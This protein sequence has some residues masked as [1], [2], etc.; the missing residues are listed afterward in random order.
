M[1]ARADVRRP[2]VLSWLA[3]IFESHCHACTAARR[4]PR[5]PA[6]IF[7]GLYRPRAEPHVREG[8]A[9]ENNERE[10]IKVLDFGIA[11]VEWAE[12]RLTNSEIALG[13]PGYRSPEQEQG[14]EVDA[15]TDLYGLGAVLLECLTG[16]LPPAGPRASDSGESSSSR[17][18]PESGVHFALSALPNEWRAIIERAM[19]LAPRERFADARAMREALL[20]TTEAQRQSA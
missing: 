7:G 20:A 17:I 13:T 12:T 5:R 1:H 9:L 19:A 8:S 15:R 16:K 18:L 3:S 2:P 14:L 10:R 11:R 6:R 4:R